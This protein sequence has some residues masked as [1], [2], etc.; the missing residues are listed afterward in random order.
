MA[1]EENSIV[2]D[3]FYLNSS[4]TTRSSLIS[5]QL[6]STENYQIWNRAIM[7]GLLVKNKIFFID[8]TCPRES[9]IFE[10]YTHLD[11]C[12]AIVKDWICNVVTKELASGLVYNHTAQSIW[13]ELRNMF[14]KVDET[15]KFQLTHDIYLA[16]QGTLPI[17]AYFV[18]LMM[19]WDE[20]AS[21]DDL[22]LVCQKEYAIICANKEKHKLISFLLGLNETFASFCTNLLLRQTL[23]K[24]HVAY[25]VL[26]PQETQ[27]SLT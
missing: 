23:S 10:Q 24:L 19:L 22:M 7:E 3:M 21:I 2:D 1:I 26:L 18:Y 11:W 27:H 15:Q 17:T 20:L 25:S 12:N 8:D 4:D 9:I 16:T 6:L 14:S 13:D 5:F